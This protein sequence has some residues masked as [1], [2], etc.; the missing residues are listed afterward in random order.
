MDNWA[1]FD[2]QIPSVPY[3]LTVTAADGS[4]NGG[5]VHNSYFP[6]DTKFSNVSFG[7]SNFNN[8]CN[9]GGAT[10]AGC[11]FRN[12]KFTD[13]CRFAGATVTVALPDHSTATVN[14]AEAI[15]AAV[16]K[17]HSD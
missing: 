15:A 9:F 17:M 13:S 6:C 16:E 4:G 10:F 3:V 11:D 2:L 1:R 14:I 7:R 8:D 12:A 5:I